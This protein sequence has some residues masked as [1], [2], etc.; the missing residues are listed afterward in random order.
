MYKTWTPPP[1]HRPPLWTMDHLHGSLLIFEVEFY[2]GGLSDFWGK[3]PIK[4]H[5]LVQCLFNNSESD[6]FLLLAHLWWVICIKRVSWP[7]TENCKA[8]D[9]RK[10]SHVS[11]FH[12][13]GISFWWVSASFILF[14]SPPV[15]LCLNTYTIVFFLP[16]SSMGQ[17][18]ELCIDSS[19][20][21]TAR[22]WKLLADKVHGYNVALMHQSID[23]QGPRPPGHTWEF[24]TD[25]VL[26]HP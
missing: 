18:K 24:N 20:H 16:L 15:A 19:R 4:R 6:G 8:L 23:N 5:R 13:N 9:K 22:H 17:L 3:G 26:K 2:W 14:Y 12:F 25:P 10:L 1:L 7:M 21:A 11:D